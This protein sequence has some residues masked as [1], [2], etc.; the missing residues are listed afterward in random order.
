MIYLIIFSI[1]ITLLLNIC[2]VKK[3]QN[4]TSRLTL[5][6][7]NIIFSVLFIL[8][9][10]ICKFSLVGINYL[11]D[12]QIEKLENKIN[13]YYPNALSKEFDTSQIK[14]MLNEL[15]NT[16]ISEVDVVQNIIYDSISDLTSN[17]LNILE[18]VDGQNNKAT[19]K[20]TMIK[21]KEIS[22]DKISP[23]LNLLKII[24]ISI[25][26][27]YI[28]ISFIITLCCMKNKKKQNTGIIFGEEA[29]KISAG[30]ENK[31]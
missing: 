29:D 27:I 6:F 23:Y 8:S 7:C 18:T 30:M 5:Y 26:A 28:L 22:L 20:N 31:N 10:L 3:I 21:L 13:Y 14:T 17:T 16:E 12:N 9:M 11:V 15:L 25:Y 19:I 4:K 1:L 24:F 2:F